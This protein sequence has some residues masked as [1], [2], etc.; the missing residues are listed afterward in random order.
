[1][2]AAWSQAANR[3]RTTHPG[4]E[5]HKLGASKRFMQ[6]TSSRQRRMPADK[7]SPCSP[8]TRALYFASRK[9]LIASFL[10]E[11]RI[12]WGPTGPP[13]LVESIFPRRTANDAE[14]L[15]DYPRVLPAGVDE[16][17]V[18]ANAHTV[19]DDT[20]N[21]SRSVHGK[22]TIRQKA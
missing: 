19:G 22:I 17:L 13:F 6:L 10:L 3:F 21:L 9:F 14:K 1:M 5:P 15:L 2:A 18:R 8:Q 4:T 7:R 20:R 12:C 11:G 16:Q